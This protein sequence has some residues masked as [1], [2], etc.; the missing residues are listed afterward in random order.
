MTG[1]R[2]AFGSKLPSVDGSSPVI[3]SLRGGALGPWQVTFDERI[4]PT[5][6]LPVGAMVPNIGSAS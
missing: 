2:V 1:I 4:F 3:L 5:P 6:F